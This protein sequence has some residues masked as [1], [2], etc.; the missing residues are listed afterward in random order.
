MAVVAVLTGLLLASG[1]LVGSAVAAT[2]DCTPFG[3]PACRNLTPVAECVW[4]NGNGSKTVVWGYRNPSDQT[5]RVYHGAHNRV[6]PG[7]DDQGQPVLFPPGTVR[8]AFVTTSTGSAS[9]RLGNTT[10]DVT[11]ATAACATK[12]V[13]Q[14]GSM[15]A[16]AIG[17]FVLSMASLTLVSPRRRSSLIGA[18]S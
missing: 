7:A 9:W 16:L 4:D 1:P 3:D 12:P 2:V 10:V 14:V 18:S 8:N 6:R 13:P 11:G 17:L 5:L 15:G